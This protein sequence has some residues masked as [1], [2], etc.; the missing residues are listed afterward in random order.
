MKYLCNYVCNVSGKGYIVHPT[1]NS[2]YNECLEI[3]YLDNLHSHSYVS[4]EFYNKMSNQIFQRIPLE[5][6]TTIFTKD[7][8]GRWSANVKLIEELLDKET[9]CTRVSKT[10]EIKAT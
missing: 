10:L 6:S 4:F 1:L 9:N 3:E 7:K 2:E 8:F 5:V